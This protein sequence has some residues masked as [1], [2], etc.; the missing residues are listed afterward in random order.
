MA[1]KEEWGTIGNM[2]NKEPTC[3][4]LIAEKAGFIGRMIF[5]KSAN[6]SKK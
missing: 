6:F 1:K 2:T 3:H 4:V 5:K